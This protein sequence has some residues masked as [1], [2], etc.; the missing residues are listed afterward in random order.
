MSDLEKERKK[1]KKEKMN[2]RDIFSHLETTNTCEKSPLPKCKSTPTPPHC[3]ARVE[4]A[5]GP[6]TAREWPEMQC[7]FPLLGAEHHQGRRTQVA[8]RNKSAF[9]LYRHSGRFRGTAVCP[10]LL[11]TR[12]C[13]SLPVTS[14]CLTPAAPIWACPCPPTRLPLHMFRSSYRG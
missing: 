2:E 4:S 13:L 12:C 6:I 1:G 3:L 10:A 9:S 5:L 7:P 14:C 8:I 11:H